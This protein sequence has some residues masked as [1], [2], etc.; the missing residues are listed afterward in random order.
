MTK[1]KQILQ[2]HLAKKS[3]R[4]IAR[5]LKVSRNTVSD[6]VQ[7]YE[8]NPLDPD[9]LGGMSESAVHQHLFPGASVIER[10]QPDFE[11]IHSEL[12]RPGVTLQL[13]WGEYAAEC[14][15]ASALAYQYSRFCDLYR[16]FVATNG[17]TAPLI[18]KPG[19]AVMVDWAGK[20][21]WMFDPETGKKKKL[22]VFVGALPYSMY[23]YALACRSMAER[24]WIRAHVLMFLHFGGV[25]RI[26]TCDNTKTGVIHNRVMED[27]LL[28]RTYREFADYYGAALLPTRVKA[29]QD[30]AAVESTVNT[31]T[32]HII[33]PL[34]DT[35]FTSVIAAN[36]AISDLL[37][38]VNSTPFQKRYG[39]REQ[40]FREEEAG[41]L[42]KLP[43]TPFEMPIWKKATVQKNC[44]I[45]TDGHYYSVPYKYV[46]QTAD[47]RLTDTT[48]AVHIDDALICTHVRENDPRNKYVTENEHLPAGHRMYR[49]WDGKRFVH[50]AESFGPSCSQAVR[51][52]LDSYAIEEQAYKTLF[53]LLSLPNKYSLA[54]LDA[55]CEEVL[56]TSSRP[57]LKQ[58]ESVMQDQNHEAQIA[59]I[60]Q[61]KANPSGAITR[62][63]SYYTTTTQEDK[64][65]D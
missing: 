53:G 18:H 58:I 21:I 31:V 13:L 17:L 28:N 33:A 30:K 29:P 40:V 4:A 41:L 60:A 5:T 46:G 51:A 23:L 22:Y 65:H 3:G 1:T 35:V 38:K 6:V 11:S 63:S 12:K 19:N 44:H 45:S 34:R 43:E 32:Q 36:D 56:K 10:V 9:A 64:I 14:E 54:N 61:Q 42:N 37:E 24:D 39:S 52:I 15:A 59:M 16:S 8:A 57:R 26:L 48:V 47:V 20:T 62:G 49:E 50:W 25:P 27:P 7:A 2:Q 55:A